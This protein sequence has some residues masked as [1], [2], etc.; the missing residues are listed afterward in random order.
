M[1]KRGVTKWWWRP[2]GLLV[3][4]FLGSSLWCLVLALAAKG[5][6]I[7]IGS[8]C[9][10]VGILSTTVVLFLAMAIAASDVD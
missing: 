7:E 3:A 5:A 1:E 6:G 2:T 10:I 9:L 8:T 4:A